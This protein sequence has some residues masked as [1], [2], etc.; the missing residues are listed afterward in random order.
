MPWF[1]KSYMR[2]KKLARRGEGPS[3]SGWFESTLVRVPETVGMIEEAPAVAT[4]AQEGGEVHE[5]PEMAAAGPLL[6][7]GATLD[8]TPVADT[9]GYGS[10]GS[11]SFIPSVKDSEESGSEEIVPEAGPAA[12]APPTAGMVEDD[13]WYMSIQDFVRR[14]VEDDAGAPLDFMWAHISRDEVQV[15]AL[16]RDAA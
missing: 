4:E 12:A 2:P 11:E 9:S 3:T 13:G 1:D 16:R 8:T 10:S 7:E 15:S 6:A 5:A 14:E